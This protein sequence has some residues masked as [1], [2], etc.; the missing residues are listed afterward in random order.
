MEF[1]SITIA[2]A[3]KG[4]NRS[5]FLP[6]IQREFRWNPEDIEKLFDSLMLDFP[7][8]SFLF[9]TL[10]RD[11]VEQHWTVYE[12]IRDFDKEHPH[13]PEASLQGVASTVSLVLDGQQRL[14]AFF[15]GLKGSYHFK[16]Y[17]WRKTKLYLNLLKVS[18]QDTDSPDDLS[19]QFEFRESADPDNPDTELWYEVGQILNFREPEDAKEAIKSLLA[20]RTEEEKGTAQRHIGRL[21][22]RIHTLKFVNFYD[23]NH[24]PAKSYDRVLNIFVRTNSGGMKLGYSDLLLSTATAKWQS[25]KTNA[26]EEV[27]GFVDRLNRIGS[28]YDFDNDFVLK[29]SLYLT[30]PLPIEYKVSNFTRP[31]M[32][33]IE[34]NWED[35]KI[36][37]ECAVRLVSKFGFSSL[38][39]TSHVALLPIALFLKQREAPHFD[40]SSERSDVEEQGRINR[41]LV[42]SL[43]RGAFGAHSDRRLKSIQDTI[44][45]TASGPSSPFPAQAI[46]RAIDMDREV[47]D[48]ECDSYLGHAYHGRYTRLILSLMYPD[49]DWKNAVFHEDHIFPQSEF[50]K[51]GLRKRGYPEDKIERYVSLY[52]LVP[53]LELLTGQENQEKSAEPFDEWIA[54]R[55]DGF[56][57]RHTIPILPNYEFDAF[58]EFYKKRAAQMR[59]KLKNAI[60]E[61]R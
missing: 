1:R 45:A 51:R 31:N 10:P 12:F 53:N 38:N 26:R 43:L 37:I 41:W 48:A 20:N 60:G 29:G 16:R 33:Q 5:I 44:L 35:I 2:D 21:H 28:G 61:V 50:D 34:D 55:D 18:P 42:V 27:I 11:D 7:I 6:A 56:K 17:K 59:T 19:Y 54:T 25:Q 15:I 58:E 8:A 13:N 36:Y 49:R 4:L 3:I 30:P 22:N 39:L 9:W 32:L 46:N 57:T 40:K 14:T 52:N 24:T 23:E 47:T